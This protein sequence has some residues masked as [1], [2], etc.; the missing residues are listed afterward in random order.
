MHKYQDLRTLDLMLEEVK[1]QELEYAEIDI[2]HQYSLK[3]NRD[4]L[5]Q[6]KYAVISNLKIK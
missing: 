2:N 3:S 4:K 1:E 6:K 5:L